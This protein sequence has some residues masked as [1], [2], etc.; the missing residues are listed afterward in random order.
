MVKKKVGGAQRYRRAANADDDGGG[1]G[2][3]GG[4]SGGGGPSSKPSSHVQRKVSRKVKFLE[5]ER[6]GAC[7]TEFVSRLGMGMGARG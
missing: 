5:R 1:S 6:P 3:G 2:G 7:S 4:G